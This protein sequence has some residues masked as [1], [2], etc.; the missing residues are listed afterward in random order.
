MKAGVDALLYEEIARRRQR[1]DLAERD[2]I[3]SLLIQARD[4]NGE[5]MSDVELRDE[6]T[7]L[8]AA[9]HET[10]AT[11]LAWFFDLV[12]RNP[13]TLQRLQEEAARG[14]T[15][16]LD[17]AI[18]ETLRLRHVVPIVVRKLLEPIDLT[19]YRLP[20]GVNVACN[21]LLIHRRED[22]YPDPE[23]FRPERFLGRNPDMYTW[24]P[25]GGG[26]RRCLGASFAT[27]EMRSVI[28]VVLARARLRPASSRQQRIRRRMVTLAP[29]QGTRVVVEELLPAA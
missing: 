22:L 6:L 17:A 20:A 9:G 23:Q 26:I 3:L 21:I 18:R 4:D 27:F 15:D 28:P 25:F 12:L 19:D 7:T 2:D 5:P 11:A 13:H 8:L 14:E 10:T 16:Y 24:I 1:A 29:S